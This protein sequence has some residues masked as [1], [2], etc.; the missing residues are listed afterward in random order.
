MYINKMHDSFSENKKIMLLNLP[1]KVDDFIIR[2]L[3][4]QD[5][6]IY[7]NWPDYPSPYEMFNTSLKN[8]PFAERDKRWRNYCEN[9]NILSL[10]VEHEQEKVVGKFSLGEID[11]VEKQVNNIGIRMHPHWCNKGYGTKL[12]I[13]ISKWC[14]R[15]GIVKI[16]FDVLSTN[17]RAIKSY[18]KAGYKII[19]E[20]SDNNAIFYWMELKCN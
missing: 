18:K 9:N 19:D 17:Y 7:A 10:V 5:I 13:S 4:R 1:F 3:N 14:F 6:D 15:N 2:E 16:K 8:E 11:W 20:F 12:L